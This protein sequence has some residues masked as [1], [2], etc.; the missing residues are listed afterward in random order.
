M[1]L[2]LEFHHFKIN[3]DYRYRYRSKV[4]G[5]RDP[6]VWSS[7][8][9]LLCDEVGPNKNLSATFVPSLHPRFLPVNLSVFREEIWTLWFC[10]SLGSVKVL[11]KTLFCDFQLPLHYVCSPP[12]KSFDPSY[13]STVHGP[14]RRSDFLRIFS[15]FT[16]WTSRRLRTTPGDP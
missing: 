12:T 9:T 1:L 13:V 16:S 10:G 14:G 8:L 6:V 2:D 15:L 3:V 5:S 7:S 4:L 11:Q